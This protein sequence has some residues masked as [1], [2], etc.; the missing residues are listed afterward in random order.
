MGKQVGCVFESGGKS[1]LQVFICSQMKGAAG[2]LLLAGERV[3]ASLSPSCF[4]RTR[5]G[6]GVNDIWGFSEAK[7][8]TSLC[9]HG[10]LRRETDARSQPGLSHCFLKSQAISLIHDSDGHLSGEMNGPGGSQEKE[11]PRL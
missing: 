8:P 9:L 6:R 11:H 4:P 2:R 3:Q 7:T 5:K 10:G 1:G